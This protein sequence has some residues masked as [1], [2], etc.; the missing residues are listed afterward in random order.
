M[1]EDFLYRDLRSPPNTTLS[2]ACAAYFTF[3]VFGPVIGIEAE[4][5][6]ATMSHSSSMGRGTLNAGDG[7]EKNLKNILM[8]P[9]GL[10]RG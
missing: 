10:E 4:E 5:G 3:A 8:P 7:Y 6:V 1:G 9:E 2:T